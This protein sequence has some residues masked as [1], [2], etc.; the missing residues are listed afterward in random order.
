MYQRVAAGGERAPGDD[1]VLHAHAIEATYGDPAYGGN[2]HQGG[3]Q[4]IGFPPPLF[5]PSRDA[6]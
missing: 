3:W 6:R 1:R 5:P 2:R 4:R